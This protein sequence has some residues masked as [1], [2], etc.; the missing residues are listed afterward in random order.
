M[1]AVDWVQRGTAARKAVVALLFVALLGG[2]GTTA[3]NDTFDLPS[4]ASG[5]GPSA[6]GKQLLVPQPTALGALDR[7]D[8]VVRV[9]SSQLQY[10]AQA[11]WSDK[12]TRMV[13]AKLVEAFENSHRVGGVGVPGQG[14][15]IDYQVVTDIRAF[16]INVEQ[17]LAVV[18]ISAKILNDRT[19]AIRAQHVFRK[20][21]P[22][23]GGGNESYIK[24]LDRTFAAVT[25]EIVDWTLRAI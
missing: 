23:G 4:T 18:E 3:K 11:Q 1:I 9:T 17:H 10:L 15:A 12:L 5:E 24:A 20:T 2:C 14:L 21:A 19:G 13:Q 25:T 7:T 22:I 8:I 16:E 6:R